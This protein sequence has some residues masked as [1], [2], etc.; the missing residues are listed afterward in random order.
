MSLLYSFMLCPT[1]LV[2]EPPIPIC[3][4]AGRLVSE[5]ELDSAAN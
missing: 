2:K 1:N 5:D 4:E 3:Y